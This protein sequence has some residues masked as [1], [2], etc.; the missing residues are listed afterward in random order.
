MRNV[1]VVAMHM[2]LTHKN[3]VLIFDQTGTGPSGYRLNNRPRGAECRLN[4]AIDVH[5]PSCY[6]HSVEYHLRTKKRRPLNIG[7]DPFSSAGSF[8][9][10][11]TLLQTGGFDDGF[12]KIQIFQ[13]CDDGSCDWN[14]YRAKLA[15]NRWHASSLLLPDDRV[16][17]V[18]GRNTF[19]YEFIP[20]KSSKELAINLPF[21]HQTNDK[22]QFGSN[23]YPFLHLTPDGHLFIF[24]NKDSILL[25]Y[26]IGKVIKT[27]PRIPGRG[28]RTFPG[29]GSS[30]ILPLDYRDG[31]Q[32]LEVMVCGGA[33]E[34]AYTEARDH[35]RFLVGLNTCGR[36]V[37]TGKTNNWDME[38]MPG[39]RL[40]SD[41]LILPTGHLLLI[42]G[43]QRG[44]GGSGNAG[45][46][47]NSPTLY[48]PERLPGK[49]FSVLVSS[50]VARMY[51]SSAV[52][53]P[54][55]R[56]LVGGGDQNK[57]YT[58]HNVTYPTE[59][60]LQA[61]APQYAHRKFNKIRPSN[62]SLENQEFG[63]KTAYTSAMKKSDRDKTVISVKYGKEFKVRFWL[64]IK[65]K[66]KKVEFNAYAPPFTTHSNSMNQRMLK[67]RRTNVEGDD[68]WIS[69]TV[70]APPSPNVAP[71]GYY[72]LFV[73]NGGIPGVAQWVRFRS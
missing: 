53:L 56:V 30:V 31:F 27:Y 70:E 68:M 72:M 32:T 28:S 61:F 10:N 73:L 41:M 7:P 71:P 66:L 4:R 22:S 33:A 45:H 1:G 2:A 12:R 44:A 17:I 15:E 58:Y 5:D 69:A 43:A 8:L 21:L 55:G 9:S 48:R 3:T 54:D 57:R 40:M 59:L 46:P 23:L 38:E 20:K 14:M 26:K 19:S 62:I 49:R 25:N 51:K 11:G 50:G 67:L 60:R 35:K 65:S 6:A 16:I 37:I 13:P 36:M 63:N 29:P 34:G 24:A 64:G 42:N 18:G 47:A 52:L 39:P